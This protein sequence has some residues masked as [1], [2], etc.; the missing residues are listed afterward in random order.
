MANR[1]IERAVRVALLTAGAVSVGAYSS[2]ALAQTQPTGPTPDEVEQIIVTGSRIPQPNLEGTSPVTM[3]GQ[4][5]VKLQGTMQVEDLINNLPM[6]FAGQGGNISN[7]A[8]GTSTINLRDL[9][10]NR[11]LVLVNGRRL[12][13]GSPRGP[14]A[15]DINF[16]PAA[17]IK[18]V[19]VLTGGASAVYG[20]D[21]VAGVVNFILVNDF[22][23]AQF[24]GNYSAYQHS[25]DDNFMRGITS[26]HNYPKAP[27]SVWDGE[28]YSLSMTLGSNFADG[29]GNATLFFGYNHVDALLQSERDS[30]SCALAWSTTAESRYCGGSSTSYPGRFRIGNITPEGLPRPG[31]FSRTMNFAN[32]PGSQIIPFNANVYAYNYGPLNYYQRPQDQYQAAAF[33]HYD[34]T[35]SAQVYGEFMFMDTSTVAQIAPSGDFG[36]SIH[37][38]SCS[39]PLLQQDGAQWYNAMCINP[40]DGEPLASRNMITQRRNVEGGGRQDDL[41]LT[42][43]R[44]VVGVKG[45]FAEHWNYDVAAQYGK[46]L[47]AETYNND[48]SSVRTERA[49]NVVTDPLTGRPACASFVDG[50]DPNCVPWNIWTQNGVTPQALNY[51]SVP[52]F[53]RGNTT[54]T[55]VTATVSSN[56]GDYGIAL[57]TA[58]DGVGVAFGAEYRQEGLK[59]DS[60]VSFQTGDLAG[61]GGPTLPVQ[62]SYNV[63]DL[64]GEVRIPIVQDVA[65]A[66]DLTFNGSYR[67]SDYSTGV[68]TSTYGLGLDWTIIDDVK[69]RGSY[70]HAVRAPNVVELF[71]PAGLGLYDMNSDP[72]GESM[73]YS[74]AACVNYTGLDPTLYGTD[75]DSTAGQYNAIFGGNEN[76]QPEKADTWTVGIVLTP[77]FLEGFTMTV[78]YWNIEVGD[79]IASVPPAITLTQCLE[80]GDPSFCDLV[81]RDSQGT[82][83]LLSDANIN[84][85]NTNIGTTTTSGWDVNANYVLSMNDWGSLNFA[86]IGTYLDSFTTAPTPGLAPVKY[87]CAGFFA[88]PCGVPAPTWRSKFRTTWSTPW[89]VD[90]SVNWRYF[91]SVD[92]S[93]SSSDPD[94]NNPAQDF[95]AVNQIDAQNY[96]DLAA[97]YTFAEKYTLSAGINNIFD[98]EAPV[99]PFVGAGFGNGNTY[100]Q[101]YDALGRYVFFGLTAKF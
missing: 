11:T 36:N 31:N 78:D 81:H 5:E 53:Q 73:Q 95:P 45:S 99:N 24:D 66:K 48:F 88:P 30:S 26:D 59:L 21:A 87:D 8:S 16:I 61:Q 60:D 58:Q 42:Q 55:V 1:N 82:L 38:I 12:P 84:A 89:N 37:T 18:R 69:L 90:I 63:T 43:Y 94:L 98:E 54:Q 39:N 19:E 15:P 14:I 71:S 68:N 100:P 13:A 3:L 4:Q 79:T 40:A 28:A 23:G 76:L 49:L 7:G 62:G 35:D 25:N 65:F 64:F 6:A 34:V 47:Y 96:I 33:M 52:G 41:G 72:C 86:L 22:E 44:G 92:V 56:L 75:L 9:G 32:A 101:V 46:V 85:L 29:K 93:G 57:P 77:T 10:S 17:L 20:S 97:I 74:Q 51:V 91:G 50:T 70:Q 2:G 27:N 80:T 67:Y 83:W